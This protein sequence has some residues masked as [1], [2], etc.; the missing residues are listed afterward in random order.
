MYLKSHLRSVNHLKRLV[1]RISW[2]ADTRGIKKNAFLLLN[3]VTLTTNFRFEL[4]RKCLDNQLVSLVSADRIKVVR[5]TGYST[6]NKQFGN[7]SLTVNISFADFDKGELM[8]ESWEKSKFG[9]T[10]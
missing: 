3:P 10:K 1:N 6:Y 2:N 4:T 7:K 9:N 8:I 5:P